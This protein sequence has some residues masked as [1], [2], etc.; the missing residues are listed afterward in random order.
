MADVKNAALK[1]SLIDDVSKPA[2]TVAQALKDAEGR[3][4]D[5]AKAMANTGASDRLQKSLSS[6]KLSAKDVEAVS[7]A[8][9]DYSRSAALGTDSTKWTKEQ[10]ASVRSWETQTIRSLRDVKREQQAFFKAQAVAEQQAAAARRARPGLFSRTANNLTNGF[11]GSAAVMAAGGGAMH[12]TRESIAAGA[13]VQAERVRMAAAGIGAPEIEAAQSQAVALVAQYRNIH[14]AH[15]METYKELRSVLLNPKEAPEMLPAAVAAKSAMNAIDKTGEMASGLQFAVKGAEVMGL[16]Q[17]PERFRKYLD[18]FIRA[19]QVMGKTITPEQ[20]YDMAK[21]MRASG[22]SLSDR[23]K[24]TTAVSLGQ[25]LGG[26]STGKAIDQF[27][28]QMVGGFQGQQH[29]AAKEF[30]ALGLASKDDFETTK[31]G[32]I[33]GMKHG[34]KVKGAD[35]A[36]TD[37]D[38]WVYQ[39]LL[40]AL[41]KAG[42]KDPQDQINEIRRLFPAGTAADLVAKMITQRQSYENHAKLYEAAQGLGANKTNLTDPAV[43]LNSL[44]TALSN[45]GAVLTSPVMKNAADVMNWMG[46]QIGAATKGLAEFNKRYPTLAKV[47][48]AGAVAGGLAGAGL[49]LKAGFQGLAGGFGLK[50]S[51]AALG[52]SASA[53]TA[54]AERLSLAGG[55]P[56][57]V[58]LPKRAPGAIGN[59]PKGLGALPALGTAGSVAAAGV[60]AGAVGAAAVYG[61]MVGL[62]AVGAV[63]ETRA[64]ATRAAISAR[65]HQMDLISDG[66]AA[67]RHGYWRPPSRGGAAPEVAPHVDASQIEALPAKAQEA[68]QA[69]APLNGTFTP[70]VD[71]SSV[72][73]LVSALERAQSLLSALHAGVAHATQALTPIG[74]APGGHFGL[75]GIQG[76]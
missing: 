9:K 30:V 27:I 59:A 50:G 72:E 71:S 19:Q 32:E 13:E 35:L 25:E 47:D 20:Q 1:I 6:L 65:Q 3:V 15:A 58:D 36:A 49:L 5:I 26:S 67:S 37:P 69:L 44:T 54:A 56:G 21:Y 63:D 39:Y 45:F 40:P 29:A 76:G 74:K 64:S 23:F 62:K 57:L 46:E 60:A 31:N 48:A 70:V 14:L 24:T 18:A 75:S 38:K 61:A 34:H 51:A 73:A 2:R 8:W 42:I 11:L 28:K 22:A 52:G 68:Q 43:A 17:D 55:K 33:K 4:R 12:A 66:V 41:E 10:V 16:A 53:L 7:A